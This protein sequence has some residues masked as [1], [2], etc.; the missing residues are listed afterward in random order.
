MFKP[1]RSGAI[2]EPEEIVNVPIPAPITLPDATPLPD[3]PPPA[4]VEPVKVPEPLV[5]A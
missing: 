3:S 1:Y 5:P 2:G 4:P